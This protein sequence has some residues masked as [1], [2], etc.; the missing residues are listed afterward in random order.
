MKYKVEFD[1][2]KYLEYIVNKD[3]DKF[4]DSQMIDGKP[5]IEG[6]KFIKADELI[7]YFKYAQKF[8]KNLYKGGYKYE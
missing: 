1:I 7:E 4:D 3:V 6:F 8:Y 2:Q 5:L